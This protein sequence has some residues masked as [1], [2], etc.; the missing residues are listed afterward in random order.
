M[1]THLDCVVPNAN[2]PQLVLVSSLL[3]AVGSIVAA[4]A[5]NFTVVYGVSM[6]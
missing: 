6:Q 4:V 2:T 5:N 1:E 3:F